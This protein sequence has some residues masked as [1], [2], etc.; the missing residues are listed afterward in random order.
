MLATNTMPTKPRKRWWLL[1][2]VIIILITLLGLGSYFYF[3]RQNSN[4]NTLANKKVFEAAQQSFN[5][6]PGVGQLTSEERKKLEVEIEPQYLAGYVTSFGPNKNEIQSAVGS[7]G[8]SPGPST[9]KSY[10]QNII[11]KKL[12]L[13]RSTGYYQ[14]YL[15][16]FWFGNTISNKTAAENIENWGNSNVL[17]SDRKYAEERAN[18]YRQK[19]ESGATQPDKVVDEV[20]QDKRLRLHDQ[21]NNSGYFSTPLPLMNGGSMPV[22]IAKLF[23]EVNVGQKDSVNQLLSS[24]KGKGVS[25]VGLIIADPGLPSSG[26]KKE[27]GFIMAYIDTY[28]RGQASI[29]QY[30][31]QLKVAR[32]LLK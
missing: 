2:L 18:Y 24:I 15:F 22:E 21:T 9:I 25:K 11:D 8:E 10:I 26:Q 13:A 5:E 7:I 28:L 27:V 4:A 32:S 19:L 3:S 31:D 12:E 30:E 16:Y 23:G 14:G 1:I 17:A 6:F 29:S 20:N